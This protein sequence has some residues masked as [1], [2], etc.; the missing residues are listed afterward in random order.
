MGVHSVEK[1]Q[2]FATGMLQKVRSVF[3]QV[4]EPPRAPQGIRPAISLSDC[5]MSALAVF[6]LKFPSLLQ[7][8]EH[9]DTDL[10]KHNLSTLYQVENAPD[11]TNMRQRLDKVD[12]QYIRPAFT[13]IF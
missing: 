8:D 5:L 13:A 1:K 12:P 6:G 7:F 2:L 10:V 4:P 3:D 9:S 11:D